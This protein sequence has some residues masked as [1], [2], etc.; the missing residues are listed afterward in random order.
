MAIAAGLRLGPYEIQGPLGAGG[1]GEVYKAKDTRLDR[2]VAIKIL[3]D[4]LAGDAQFRG[5]FEREARTISQLDDPHICAL[6][7]VGEEKGMSFLVMQYLEGETLSARL[8]RS[9]ALSISEA[10]KIAIEIAGALDKAHRVGVIHRDLKPGNVMLTKSGA[11]LLDFGLAKSNAV[12][13]GSVSVLPTTPVSITAQGT[14]LGTFQYMAP[15]QVEGGEADARTDLF[16]FGAVLYEM[17]TGLPAFQGKT[18]ASL[19]GS[20]MRDDPTMAGDF[21]A[22]LPPALGR[23]IRA[24]LAKNPD[25]RIQTAHDVALQLQWILEGGS[26]V[27]VSAPAAAFP[28]QT[29]RSRAWL[30]W[31]ITAIAIVAAAA[32]AAVMLTRKPEPRRIMRFEVANPEGVFN[33]GAPRLSPDGRY[34]AFNATDPTG[35]TKIWVRQLNSLTAQPLAGTDG[36]ARPFWS[37]D[38]RFLGFMADGKL[39]KIEVTGGPAQKICDAPSGADGSWSPEGVILYDGRGSD[40]IYRVPAAGGTPVVAVKAD[41]S[42]KENQVGWP[43]FLSDGKHF[44][45]L[46]MNSKIEDSSYRVGLLDSTDTQLLASAQTQLAY[47][48]PDRLLFVRDQTL[49]TQ[50]FDPKAMK[51]IGDPAPLAERIG[52]DSVGLATFSISRE[53]TLAYRTGDP[54]SRLALVDRAGRDVESFGDPG[55]YANP[56]LSRDGTRLAFDLSDKGSRKTDIWIRDLARSVNSRLTLGQGNNRFPLWSPDGATIVFT[57][58]RSGAGDLYTKAANGQ[59]DDSPLLQDDVLKFATDWS[60]DGRYIAYTRLGGNS[61]GNQDLWALPMFGDHKPIVIAA[62]NFTEGS[63]VFSPDGRFIAYRSDESGRSEIYVQSFPKATGKWQISTTGGSDP[64]W[65][66]DGKELFYRGADQRF[67]AVDV[68]LGDTVKAGVPKALFPGRVNVVGNV[69]NR[70]TSAADGQRFVFVAPLG[71][72]AIAPTTVVLNWD[73]ELKR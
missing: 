19:I 59:G 37:P 68:Q 41:P 5:R 70:Y 49:V 73:A 21:G 2:T 16:A 69:R 26:Q 51:T 14:I 72:D 36:A 33:V 25:D 12:A 28:V 47:A 4:A 18:Q 11:K 23:V 52:T 32:L 8:Q 71:R 29:R 67:M 61:N 54:G 62:G 43:E 53:G 24:C 1:M 9:G 38:S 60:R 45:Y 35:N 17:V 3:P 15:E 66:S 7:D 48:P 31:S 50:Q 63:G 40:P 10:L 44:M 46:A 55:E 20:I 58:T 42:R 34:L 39:K 56:M 30:P 64:T 6:Y 27:G 22:S 13:R 57:S 65:R